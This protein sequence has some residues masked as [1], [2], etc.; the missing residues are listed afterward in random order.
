MMTDCKSRLM[1]PNRNCNEI[2]SFYVEITW[3][4]K[5]DP[6]AWC[7]NQPEP[8]ISKMF[9]AECFLIMC[10]LLDKSSLSVDHWP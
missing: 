2:A 10:P 5:M 4:H 8:I 7:I 9:Y 3:V 1:D 6:N